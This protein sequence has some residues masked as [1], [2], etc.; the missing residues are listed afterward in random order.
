MTEAVRQIYW[1]IGEILGSLTVYL[2]A[3]AAVLVLFYG[4]LRD[5]AAW[6]QRAPRKS[7]RCTWFAA[8]A[9]IWRNRS[10][11]KRPCKIVAQA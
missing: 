11:K 2:T 8:P 9:N 1:N 6:A 5:V 7:S 4:I 3:L 10:V